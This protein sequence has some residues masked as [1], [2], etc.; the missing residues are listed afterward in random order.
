MIKPLLTTL[1]ICLFFINSVHSQKI[2]SSQETKRINE[3]KKKF[4]HAH[5]DLRIFEMNNTVMTSPNGYLEALEGDKSVIKKFEVSIETKT[6]RAEVLDYIFEEDFFATINSTK[7]NHTLTI[8]VQ[9][10]DYN[11]KRIGEPIEVVKTHSDLNTS[12]SEK[13]LGKSS[14][15]TG[16]DFYYN[17]DSK[18]S[19]L[20]IHV[21]NSLKAPYL[22]LI[23]L[24]EVF[25][26]KSSLLMEASELENKIDFITQST[27]PDGEVLAIVAESDKKYLLGYKV[28]HFSE[29]ENHQIIELLPDLAMTLGAKI[30]K[31]A[32]EDNVIISLLS[33]DSDGDLEEGGLT[34]LNYNLK[35]KNTERNSYKL[36]DKDL[37]SKNNNFESKMR[38]QKIEFLKDGSSLFFLGNA[39]FVYGEN[40]TTSFYDKNMLLVKINKKEKKNGK[41][42]SQ[43]IL[44]VVQHLI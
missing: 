15:R 14:F 5:G 35:T 16:M 43:D 40:V 1:L 2:I 38:I 20:K 21:K 30:S 27:L 18:T 39:G 29:N 6:G 32:Y 9:K 12:L 4:L 31:N 24:D 23:V 13:E 7:E 34:V 42:E 36:K 17:K 25:K 8:Y 22:K 19:L 28:I 44:E 33:Q 41:R 10:F 3:S 37:N 11:F 26:T